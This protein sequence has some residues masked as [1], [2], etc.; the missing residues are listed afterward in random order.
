MSN[1]TA[2]LDLTG[3]TEAFCARLSAEGR[4]P[5]TIAAYRRDLALVARVAGELAPGIVC[6]EVTVG[7][8]DE[9][10][11]AGAV[12]ESERGPRS[13]A[14]LHRMKAAVRA[15]FAWAA[16]T[17]VV[18][19]NPARSIRMHRLPRK[20]PVFLTTA[21]KKRLLKELKGRTD[22]STLRD[23][24]MIEVLLG[25]G[26]RLGELTALDMDDIDLDAK[27][28]RVRAKGNVPQVKFIKTDLR[29][30]LRRY[31]AERRRHGRPEMEALF[32]SNRDGRLCQRQIA[33]RL[34]HWLRKAGIEK[35]LTP[36]GLRHTF[37]THLYGA[38]N[39]LL[40]VQRALGHRDVST[41]QIYTHLV[42]GQLEEALERL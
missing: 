6:R 12:T 15:F 10:F 29:T 35:E 27:H 22:F 31:L 32:L 8:L 3:A 14:S 39:D 9:V 16:E 36:H 4:S 24:A 42:D 26:I 5:A 13:A 28:L 40:V 38:T 37:A 11:S 7:L 19:D 34:A 2:D 41:T 23:R 20:L 33:N 30:L 18:G 1:R 21:E 25:T 17:G